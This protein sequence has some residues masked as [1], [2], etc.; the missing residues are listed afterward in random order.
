MSALRWPDPCRS[1]FA[2]ASRFHVACLASAVAVLWLNAGAAHADGGLALSF[3]KMSLPSS[4]IGEALMVSLAFA[5]PAMIAG[6]SIAVRGAFRRPSRHD[7]F[8]PR[9]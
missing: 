5:L 6:L 2:F 9:F 7:V 3:G 4:W 1:A 8:R